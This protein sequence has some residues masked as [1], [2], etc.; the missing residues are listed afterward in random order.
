MAPLQLILGGARSGK[1][2]YALAQ[3]NESSF[4]PRI[5]I[6]TASPG[7]EEMKNRIEQ[8]RSTRSPEWKTVESSYH[9]VDAL[10]KSAV[11]EK[12]LIVVDCLTLWISNLLCGMGGK[13]LSM[14][15]IKNEFK[16]LEHLLPKLKGNIRFVSNEVGLGIVPD[17]PLGRN[18]RDLQGELNQSLATLANQVILMTVGLPHKLK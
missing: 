9:L 5:F 10:E 13:A 12:G 16:K 8:H 15:E 1:S 18:F 3:G 6:A 14:S 17:N 11:H 2:R 7:D 4:D